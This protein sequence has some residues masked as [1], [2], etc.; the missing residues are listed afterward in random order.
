[1]SAILYPVAESADLALG[2]PK[3][4]AERERAARLV[5]GG[6]DVEFV[7]E[8]AGPAYTTRDAALDAWAGRVEDDRPGRQRSLEP[9]DR[10]CRLVEQFA[11]RVP[12][13]VKPAN[14]E[15][16]R[17]PT[18]SE[19]PATVWRLSVSYWRPRSVGQDPEAPQAR[20]ARKGQ[21]GE[22]APETLKVIARQPLRPILPQ[23][24]LDIG[25]FEVR[26]P[27]APYSL[28]ADE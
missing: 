7:T 13:P 18:P 16:R 28:M 1:M 17:W 11:G 20:R 14:V 2:A 23:R 8:C 3:G 10:Y 12:L 15:G 22:L 5:C 4:R 27:E 25:L 6:V 21:A 9:Q 24:P 26:R 19:A